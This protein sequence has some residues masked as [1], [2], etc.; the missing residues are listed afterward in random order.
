MSAAMSPFEPRGII[1]PGRWRRTRTLGWMVLLAVVTTVEF[2]LQAAV[3]AGLGAGPALLLAAAFATLALAYGTYVVAVRFGERR[4][5]VELAPGPAARE[6]AFGVVLGGTMI[7]VVMGCL[8]LVGAVSLQAASWTHPA[9]DIRTALGTGFLEELLARLIVFRLL[10]C[11]FGM[12]AGVAISAL[13]FGAAH[14]HNPGASVLSAGAIAVEAGLLLSGFF[15]AT[16][17]IWMSIGAHAGW[18]FT[19]GT[20]FG[21][22]VSGMPVQGSI[23]RSDFAAS[24]P[25][26]L[27]GGGFGPEASV[28][29]TFIG[30]T[31]FFLTM[32]VARS[33]TAGP[34]PRPGSDGR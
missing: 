34:G 28:V 19:L 21:A 6:L 22:P 17:R 18:N 30:I 26:W 9:R 3:R 24:A 10:A 29:T 20:V 7:A 8:V 15:V 5:A 27:T 33:R 4:R 23:L 16:R 2:G 31:V 1:G 32:A 14:L 12:G 11:A 13:L 25:A